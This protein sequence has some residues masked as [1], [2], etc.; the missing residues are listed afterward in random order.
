LTIKSMINH[1]L[2]WKI[3]VN[4]RQIRS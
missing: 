1:A 4:I 2:V 3:Y